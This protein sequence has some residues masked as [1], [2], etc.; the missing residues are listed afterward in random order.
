MREIRFRA[1]KPSTSEMY[2]LIPT[3]DG[4]MGQLRDLY[5]EEDWIVMQWTGL[6]DK[7]GVDIYEGDVID[8]YDG[9]G[10]HFVEWDADDFGF[11]FVRNYDGKRRFIIL[12]G[13]N[14]A[15]I[16]NIYENPELLEET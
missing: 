12:Q 14:P 13:E 6:Q 11:C 5:S 4:T 9:D 2:S 1:W 10:I 7:N 16:G 8:D 3:K 15:V